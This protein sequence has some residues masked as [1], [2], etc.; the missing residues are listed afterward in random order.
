MVD[1]EWHVRTKSGRDTRCEGSLMVV[2]PKN[3]ICDDYLWTSLHERKINF[4]LVLIFFL[5]GWVYT[6]E[7]DFK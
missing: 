6:A 3:Y 5:G 2:E 7:L 1:Q 4:Y